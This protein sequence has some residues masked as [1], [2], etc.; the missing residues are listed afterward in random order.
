MPKMCC[1]TTL[2]K[3]NVQVS[4]IKTHQEVARFFGH[5]V[6]Q[7]SF[8]CGSVTV[9]L[10]LTA[11]GSGGTVFNRQP[12]VPYLLTCILHDV[13]SLYLVEGFNETGTCIHLVSVS[14]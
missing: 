10:T 3:L 4:C 11:S 1:R 6:F 8:F 12:S 7:L 14:R 2:G 9:L 5:G 13:P